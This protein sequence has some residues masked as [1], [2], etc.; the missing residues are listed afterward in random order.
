MPI[1]R[2]ALANDLEALLRTAP[3]R[4]QILRWLLAG[5]SAPLAACGGGAE[6]S[7]G[8][9]G[10]STGSSSSD[11]A[12]TV[13][14]C[15]II[16]EETAGPYPGDGSN[17]NSNGIANALSLSGIVR[18]DI[19]RSI[20]G[21]TGT[22]A[23]I[24][25]TLTLQLVNTAGNCANLAGYAIYLWHCTRDGLYSMYSTGVTGENFLRGV[26]QTDSNGKATFLTIFPGCY[27]GR[28]P[29][30]HFEVY[31]S[32][33]S[34][35]G[36]ANKVKTSQIAFPTATCNDVYATSGYGNSAINLAAI[37]FAS[38]NVFSDGT[39]Q[40]MASISGTTTNGYSASLVVGIAS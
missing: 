19:R 14:T 22:A 17:Y 24:P 7:I 9:V 10:S 25:L 36:A 16:P 6:V 1:P 33:A 39:E 13:S 40:Q 28:M 21:A 18:S 27:A 8:G 29:H 20:G 30:M 34:A 23:G 5:A 35:T 4:R 15:T 31:P 26:Q 12:S 37:S 38:D 2:R 11:T 32:L 3:E